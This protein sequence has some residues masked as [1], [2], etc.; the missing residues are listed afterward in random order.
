ML[1]TRSLDIVTH[2]EKNNAHS[3]NHGSP[4]AFIFHTSIAKKNTLH[5]KQVTTN[6]P[7]TFRQHKT[8][9]NKLTHLK[10]IFKQNYYNYLF[11]K[12]SHDME[13]C[14]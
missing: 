12:C 3:T 9:R 10:E 6:I 7:N 8:Y 11:Q 14:E 5:R 13:T 4:K 1:S 2:P